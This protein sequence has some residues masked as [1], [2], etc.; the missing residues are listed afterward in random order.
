MIFFVRSEI[1]S[2]LLAM[3]PLSMH[4]FCVL[5]T[6]CLV[7]FTPAFCAAP[8]HDDGHSHHDHDMDMDK[9]MDHSKHDNNSHDMH[10]H[11][12]KVSAF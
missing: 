10:M 1:P 4:L 8:H 11:M 5:L 12:M 9:D 6:S 7:L 3:S 2:H